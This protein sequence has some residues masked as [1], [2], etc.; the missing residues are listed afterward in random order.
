[1]VEQRIKDAIYGK[2]QGKFLAPP[3]VAEFRCGDEYPYTRKAVMM[4]GN[5]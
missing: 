2:N 4:L 5:T 1:M 3:R